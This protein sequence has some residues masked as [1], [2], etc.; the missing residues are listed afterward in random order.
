[1]SSMHVRAHAM[2]RRP[3]RC[4]R[5][6]QIL[7][8]IVRASELIVRCAGAVP[9]GHSG[10]ELARLSVILVPGLVPPWRRAM[11]KRDE[12]LKCEF[13]RFRPAKSPVQVLHAEGA[14]KRKVVR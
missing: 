6:A 10:P 14:G 13:G 3:K 2:Q 8:I 7:Y 12:V 9:A 5:Q 4:L 11:A 1:M